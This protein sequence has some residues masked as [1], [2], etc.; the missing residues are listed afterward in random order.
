M[1]ER[2][3]WIAPIAG[4]ATADEAT[5]NIAAT[6]AMENPHLSL[7]AKGLHA[8]VLTHEGEPIN[9]Y[10]DSYQPPELI[11]AAIEELLEAGLI[12]R[13]QQP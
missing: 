2:V 10:A 4:F 3:D 6:A 12:I 5:A 9:P 13:A 11:K 7:L 1:Q 8:L